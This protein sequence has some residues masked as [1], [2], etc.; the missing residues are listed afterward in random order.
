ML[1]R[2]TVCTRGGR[3]WNEIQCVPGMGDVGS[4]YSVYQGWVM[5]V[6]IQCVPGVGDV[7][8]RYSV[9]QGWVMLIRDTVCT[10]GG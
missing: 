4:R 8:S 2:D 6:E 9:Y 5:L 3:C 1:I 7:G 10:R